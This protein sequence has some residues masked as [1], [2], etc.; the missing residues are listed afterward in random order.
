MVVEAAQI[1]NEFPQSTWTVPPP[2]QPRRSLPMISHLSTATQ[3]LI[4]SDATVITERKD[5]SKSFTMDFTPVSTSPCLNF[6][7]NVLCELLEI[8]S[9]HVMV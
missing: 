5:S 1:Y 3:T 6:D 4:V 8:S 9:T 2:H 7:P